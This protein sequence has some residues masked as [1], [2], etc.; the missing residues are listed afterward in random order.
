[1]S[2]RNASTFSSLVDGSICA[3]DGPSSSSASATSLWRI[4]EP[5]TLA[6][7]LSSARTGPASSTTARQPAIVAARPVFVTENEVVMENPSSSGGD[8]GGTLAQSDCLGNAK[9][10]Q[11]H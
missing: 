2:I 6:S 9:V 7:T 5:F 1:M 3:S 10:G 8:F 11:N 4:S